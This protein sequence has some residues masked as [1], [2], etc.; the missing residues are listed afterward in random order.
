MYSFK[1]WCMDN[2]L[3]DWVDRW[4][5]ELNNDNPNDISCKLDEY[6]YF[7]CINKNHMSEPKKIRVLTRNTNRGNLFCYQCKSFGQYIVDKYGETML[8]TLWSDKNVESPFQIS[9]TSKDAV[10]I[11]CI[12]GKHDDYLTTPNDFIKYQ[13]CPIC[14]NRRVLRGY[15]DIATTHPHLVKYFENI[16]DAYTHTAGSYDIT[17]IRCPICKQVQ[18]CKIYDFIRRKNSCLFCG[19]GISFAN[20]FIASFLDQLLTQRSIDFNIEKSFNWSRN[21]NFISKGNKSFKR[22]DFY[23]PYN[24]GIIIEAH[25]IQH[26]EHGFECFDNGMSLEEQQ[27]NDAF[28]KSLALSNGIKEYNYIVLDCRR[29]SLEYI[30]NSILNSRL[31]NIFDDDL[32]TIDWEL[33]AKRAAQSNIVIAANMWNDGV[34]CRDIATYLHVSIGTIY[35]Y[36]KSASSI[37][38]CDYRGSSSTIG[39]CKPFICLNNGYI[40]TSASAFEQSSVAIFGR[41]IGKHYIYNIMRGRYAPKDDIQIKYLSKDEFITAQKLCQDKIIEK[42]HHE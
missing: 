27:F 10:Y 11:K 41:H 19:D 28:K 30:K 26:Y 20:K 4:D 9:K 12:N 17:T 34:S 13:S 40:F 18:V 36:L 31:P 5:Y 25:G 2:N 6:R 32:M 1:M 8:Y 24:D 23:I 7:K 42:L 39:R 38:L 33:C 16:E 15:N 3:Q 21:L 37:G 29:S 22:Y 14:N 35:N